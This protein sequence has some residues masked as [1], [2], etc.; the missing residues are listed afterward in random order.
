VFAPPTTDGAHALY[1][2]LRLAAQRFGL[3]IGDVVEISDPNTTRI[4]D[5]RSA[6]RKRDSNENG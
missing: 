1:L 5:P 6:E 4:S 3:A 2:L